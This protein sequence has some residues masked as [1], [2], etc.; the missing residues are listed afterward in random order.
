VATVVA[1]AAVVVG[2]AAAAAADPAAAQPCPAGPT[3]TCLGVST[4][5]RH[6]PYDA[7]HLHSQL[8]CL[9]LPD[10]SKAVKLNNGWNPNSGESFCIL[11]L[12]L[13]QAVHLSQ[14]WALLLRLQTA[15]ACC[16]HTLGTTAGAQ[17]SYWVTA[18]LLCCYRNLRQ[19]L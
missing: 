11:F 13:L 1:A 17:D 4:T 7:L 6:P 16:Q 3:G 18:H 15:T 5:P 2:S 10:N 14:V 12:L 9:Q 8:H 19:Q